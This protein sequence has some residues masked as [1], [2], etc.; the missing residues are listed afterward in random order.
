[1]IL[2][3]S[4]TASQSQ[5]SGKE[6]STVRE[7]GGRV[8]GSLLRLATDQLILLCLTYPNCTRQDG[9]SRGKGVVI[10]GLSDE[11]DGG[12]TPKR[13]GGVVPAPAIL[14]PRSYGPRSYHSTQAASETCG[15]VSVFGFGSTIYVV[16]ASLEV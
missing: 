9:K 6:H 2:P 4:R 3:G 7:T 13:E 12:P 10:L 1:M 8:R 14:N 15:V 16:Q 5:V 11:Q